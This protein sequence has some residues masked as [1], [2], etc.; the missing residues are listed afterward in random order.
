MDYP[1]FKCTACN[2]EITRGVDDI[3][4][5]HYNRRQ[6]LNFTSGGIGVAI[7]FSKE[8]CFQC[9]METIKKSIPE[10]SNTKFRDMFSGAFIKFDKPK[11]FERGD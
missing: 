7:E 3:I 4:K 1:T 8:H 6:E 11:R 2:K 9:S 10:A 5:S